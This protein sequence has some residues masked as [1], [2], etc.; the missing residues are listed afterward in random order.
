MV[1]DHTLFIV[2]FVGAALWVLT[3]IVE[4]VWKFYRRYKHE[5]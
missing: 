1:D 2:V 3:F 4:H 5:D